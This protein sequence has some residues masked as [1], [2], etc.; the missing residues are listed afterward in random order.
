M[1]T[2]CSPTIWVLYIILLC[3]TDVIM[4][5]YFNSMAQ[6]S[7]V[8]PTHQTRCQCCLLKSWK[9]V[10]LIICLTK[11][12]LAWFNWALGYDNAPEFCGMVAILLRFLF[13]CFFLTLLLIW[14]FFFKT[15]KNVCFRRD[16][17]QLV[18]WGLYTSKTSHMSPRCKFCCF[19]V[20]LQHS[21]PC[22]H[23]SMENNDKSKLFMKQTN[24]PNRKQYLVT[25]LGGGVTH[26]C[27]NPKMTTVSSL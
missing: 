23:G 20:P 15:W 18:F 14:G 4:C 26:F 6:L 19:I 7:L 10:C 16:M 3:D 22:T 21:H 27:S 24:K 5:Y 1:E 9:D 8:Y 17:L 11:W 13:E 2:C 25:P 12:V